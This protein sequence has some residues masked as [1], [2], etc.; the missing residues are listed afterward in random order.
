MS[1]LVYNLTAAPLLLANGL[2]TPIPAS[3]AGVGVRGKPW[4]A[5]GNELNGRSALEYTALQAQQLAL[6]KVAV[7]GSFAVAGVNVSQG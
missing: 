6:S 4:Y 5:S 2:S 7:L 3:T 1:L